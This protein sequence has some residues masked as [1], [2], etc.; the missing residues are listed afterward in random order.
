MS[1]TITTTK[2]ADLQGLLQGQL[3]GRVRNL[4]VVLREGQVALQGTALSYYAKLLAQHLAL[5]ALETAALVNEIEVR[6][7]AFELEPDDPRAG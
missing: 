5:H 6:H 1:D 7:A 4:R 3:W 2:L